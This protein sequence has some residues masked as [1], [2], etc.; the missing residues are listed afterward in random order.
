MTVQASGI[1]EASANDTPCKMI[2]PRRAGGGDARC[3]L[4]AHQNMQHT[5]NETWQPTVQQ[6]A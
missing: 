4:P 2:A 5:G 3:C 6:T 1:G